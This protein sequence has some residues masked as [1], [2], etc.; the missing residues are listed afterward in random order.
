MATLDIRTYGNLGTDTFPV[1]GTLAGYILTTPVASPTH[2]L[3]S[4]RLIEEI[5]AAVG[6]RTVFMTALPTL[7]TLPDS[8]AQ[9]IITGGVYS[10]M[11]FE[12][13]GTSII[14]RDQSG[15]PMRTTVYSTTDRD[16]IG[17]VLPTG[18]E[19]W[20]GLTEADGANAPGFYRITPDGLGGGVQVG[21]YITG[22]A[23]SG[24]GSGTFTPQV[25]PAPTVADS[26]ATTPDLLD[27][28]T[29]QDTTTVVRR[30][31]LALRA[32]GLFID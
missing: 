14:Y 25:F 27:S 31:A 1:S 24:G 13:D 6:E 19:F 18:R 3:R 9:A 32:S 11:I 8:G 12:N 16:A 30:M 21:P 2:I 20:Y 5:V 26:E 23:S 15:R 17:A 28:G 10:S 29:L 22:G 7:V 4:Q